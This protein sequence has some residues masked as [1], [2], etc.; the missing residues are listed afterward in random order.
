MQRGG[1]GGRLPAV[2]SAALRCAPV[3][4]RICKRNVKGMVGGNKRRDGA[5]S[6]QGQAARGPDADRY[7]PSAGENK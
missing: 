4:R 5:L 6:V 7:N 2:F 1:A 3:R